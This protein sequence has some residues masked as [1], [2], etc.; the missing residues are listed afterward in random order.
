MA[1][2]RQAQLDG[3]PFAP[4]N[5]ETLEGIINLCRSPTYVAIRLQLFGR[6]ARHNHFRLRP[7]SAV[8]GRILSKKHESTKS[9]KPL[10][11]VHTYVG[12]LNGEAT[13]G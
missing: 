10:D 12:L 6:W 9:H 2:C 13:T 1:A 8:V 11:L 5:R 3:A 4:Q 7:L